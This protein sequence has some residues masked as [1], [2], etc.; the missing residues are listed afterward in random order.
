MNGR[1]VLNT[2][3]YAAEVAQLAADV[4]GLDFAA[5]Q[6]WMCEPSMLAKTGLKVLEH[7]QR[8]V[9]NLIELRSLAPEIP[10]IPV[11]QGWTL[12]DYLYC[13]E[14]YELAGIRLADE[15]LVG[16]GTVCRRQHTAEGA[17]I[18]KSLA[19]LGFRLHG[20]GFKMQGLA[21]CHRHLFSSDSMAWSL[22]ARKSPPLDGCTHKSCATCMRWALRWHENLV[23]KLNVPVNQ[24]ELLYNPDHI[25]GWRSSVSALGS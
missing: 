15:P 21:S 24:P 2:H 13:V 11:L 18:I 20:F 23:Q 4:G 17:G 22:N 6:D 7:Q 8:S 19:D 16:V 5:P 25:A 1:W 10:W 9:W 12:A 3:T 14:L